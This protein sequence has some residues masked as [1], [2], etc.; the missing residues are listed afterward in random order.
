MK[1]I[2]KHTGKILLASF[3]LL[4]IWMLSL[5]M[6]EYLIPSQLQTDQAPEAVLFFRFILVCLIHVLLLYFIIRNSIWSGI[7]LISVI[8][9]LIFIIQYFLSL[10]EA[11]WFNDSLNMPLSGIWSLFLSGLLLAAIF[12]PLIVWI[13]GR[14]RS[15]E[16]Q[17]PVQKDCISINL[18][19]KIAFLVIV[20]Y[21]ALYFLAGYYIAWQSESVRLFYTGSTD[22]DPFGEM[23]I[24]NIQSGL[25][26]FQILRGLIWVGLAILLYLMLKV[27]FWEKGILTGLLFAL[28]MNAQHLL[29]NPYFPA[30]VSAV[31]FI[32]TATSNFIWGFLIVIVLHAGHS[33]KIFNRRNGIPEHSV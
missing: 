4:L 25:Y 8:F 19:W 30:R 27:S 9:L 11:L 1:I 29:P 33:A 31:H 5:F 21:P 28:L 24:G 10:I 32:E 17:Q 22:M 23:L 26:V 18:I 7:R 20:V 14:I 13:G 16:P 2:L 3:L 15:K 12:S 6:A